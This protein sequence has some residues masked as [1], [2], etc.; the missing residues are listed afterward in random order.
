M[1]A[2]TGTGAATVS[3]PQGGATAHGETGVKSALETLQ[4][5][6]PN[7]PMGGKKHAAVLKAISDLTKALADD[8]GG[9]GGG[10]Q[11]AVLQQLISAQKGA[12]AGGGP[13]PGM[14]GMPNMGGGSPMPPMGA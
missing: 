13:P 7:L 2:P 12:A 3:P 9:I 1:P 10:D 11:A 6:L 8:G 4:K 5:A 14:P